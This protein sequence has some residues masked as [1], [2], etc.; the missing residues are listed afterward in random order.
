MFFCLDPKS[1]KMSEK[2]NSVCS[3]QVKIEGN[4]AKMVPEDW[5]PDL[6]LETYR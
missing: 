6:R 4:E 2:L 3:M 1:G 5:S